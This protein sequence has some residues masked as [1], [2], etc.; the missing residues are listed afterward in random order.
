MRNVAVLIALSMSLA[1]G[2]DKKFNCGQCHQKEAATFTATGM[3]R[4]LEPAAHGKILSA[5]AKLE[6]TQGDFKYSIE[7]DG[8]TSWFRV[9]NDREEFKAKIG[10]A[11]GLG[12]AG[13]TYLIERNG[14]WYEG[15]V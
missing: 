1:V 8:D 2:A 10:W 13:Q 12:A 3:S 7:R 4:A 6:F 11:F 9:H 15:R 5:H 14:H